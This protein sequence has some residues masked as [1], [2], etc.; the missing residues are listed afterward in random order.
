MGKVVRFPV[1]ARASVIVHGDGE[2]VELW[3]SAEQARDAESEEHG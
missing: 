1:R 3:M 2:A